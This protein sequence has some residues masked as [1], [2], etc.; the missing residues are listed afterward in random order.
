MASWRW[1]K[2]WLIR[3]GD[4]EKELV[5][6]EGDDKVET[7]RS[8]KQ[9]PFSVRGRERKGKG[10]AGEIGGRKMIQMDPVKCVSTCE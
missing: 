8:K 5:E 4:G 2:S 7:N 10:K 1:R 6:Q 9:G 3:G